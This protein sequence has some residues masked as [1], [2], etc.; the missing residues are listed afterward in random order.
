[1]Q[2]ASQHTEEEARDTLGPI[3][4]IFKEKGEFEQAA[5]AL[6]ERVGVSAAPDARDAFC[7]LLKASP[8][9]LKCALEFSLDT[10]DHWFREHKLDRGTFDR[11]LALAVEDHRQ[12]AVTR[13]SISNHKIG[14]S[15]PAEL[16]RLT[17]LKEI[18]LDGNHFT[19]WSNA[20]GVRNC[21][22]S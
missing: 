16:R 18:K 9:G 10:K 17:N 20:L 1:M 22:I 14:G 7:E 2:V 6:R 11:I 19:G 13:V 3:S 4:R 5:K 21:W 15:L 12:A 8:A